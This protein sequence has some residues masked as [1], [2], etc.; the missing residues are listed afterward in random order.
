VAV[1]LV[2]AVGLARTAEYP[3]RMAR[4]NRGLD[5]ATRA[6]VLSAVGQGDSIGQVGNGPVFAIIVAAW[7]ARA[8]LALGAVVVLQAVA[9]VRT[10]PLEEREGAAR[11]EAEG[12]EV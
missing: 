2:L 3:F 9:F 4:V 5:P 7:G 6:T 10:R 12:V 1:A 8:A 11:A